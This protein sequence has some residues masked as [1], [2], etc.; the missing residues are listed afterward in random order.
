ML[1]QQQKQQQKMIK[2]YFSL[3]TSMEMYKWNDEANQV[4]EWKKK[5]KM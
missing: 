4:R 1:Q 5:N 2:N 3:F